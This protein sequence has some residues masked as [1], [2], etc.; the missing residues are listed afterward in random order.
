M[1]IRTL[2]VDDDRMYR[3]ATR[4]LLRDM[5][6]VTVVGEA[7]ASDDLLPVVRGLDP[8]VVVLCVGAD[9]DI[10]LTRT[11]EIH[12]RAPRTGIVVLAP[13]HTHPDARLVVGL[14]ARAF[15]TKDCEMEELVH[16]VHEANAFQ[17]MPQGEPTDDAPVAAAIPT[18]WEREVIGLIAAGYKHS[19]IADRLGSS[20]QAVQGCHARIRHEMRL[21]SRVDVVRYAAREGLLDLPA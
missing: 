16:A 15:L 13:Q 14:G 19:E 9:V 21:E 11:V 12:A 4:R 1:G 2:L 3:A 10:G 20:Y 6:G 5:D 8:Q 17:A 18:D 7:D